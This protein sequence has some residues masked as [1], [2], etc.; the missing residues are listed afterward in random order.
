[1]SKSLIALTATAV[2][3]AA[4]V[5]AAE[6]AAREE[7]IA[8]PVEVSYP[9]RADVYATFAA[10]AHLASEFEANVVAK[11]AG[12]VVEILAEEGDTIAAGQVLARLDGERLRLEMLQ[13]RASLEQAE[14]EYERNIDLEARGMISR[15]MFDGMQFELEAL[16]AQ[17]ELA[18]LRYDE[19][20]IRSPIDGVVTLRAVRRG[21]QLQPG[22][23]TFRVTDT[24]QLQAELKV[25]QAELAKFKTGQTA[26]LRVD[27]IP[28]RFP[29]RV[30]R[31][32]PTIN[33]ENG[34]FRVT[35]AIDNADGKLAPGMF[36]RFAVAYE[37]HESSLTVPE[38]A[39]V[40]EDEE[41]AV[42][43]LKDETVVRRA[44]TLGITDGD[45][46]EILDGVEDGDIVVVDGQGSIRDGSRVL[47]RN[48]TDTRYTE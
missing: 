9:E 42:Y 5:L 33:T 22:A 44:V 2:C 26:T 23:M 21:E 8:V 32:S 30:I 7:R 34:T 12:E 29:A 39:I 10:T 11:V 35:L 38:R 14:R 25:P 6:Q 43:L 4:P 13:A 48:S 17:Y 19:A 20:T 40:T 15:S 45:R 3:A 37:K 16:K 31:L 1:M 28:G 27:A 36:A 41:S 24:S 47:A 46:V 18:A